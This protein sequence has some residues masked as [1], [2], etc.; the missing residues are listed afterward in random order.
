MLWVIVKRELMDY[1][2]SVRFALT[3][4][5]CLGIMILSVYVSIQDYEYRLEEYKS[6]VKKHDGYA[7]S[8]NAI[9]RKPE[10]LS[11]LAQGLDRK[12]GGMIETLGHGS[13]YVTFIGAT[14]NLATRQSHYLKELASVDFVFVIRVIYALLAI[15]ISYNLIS[16]ENE[17]G[18]LKLCLSNSIPRSVIVLGKFFGGIILLLASLT[19]GFLIGFIMLL[20]SSTVQLGSDEWI[21]IGMIY[22]AS[23]LYLICF[24]SIGTFVSSLT[25]TSAA[26]L[27]VGII[28][29]LCFV[30]VIPNLTTVLAIEI[31]KIPT[32][33]EMEE[34]RNQHLAV[35][36][37][38]LEKLFE[39]GYS[40]QSIEVG[41]EYAY[42]NGRIEDFHNDYTNKLYNQANLVQRISIISPASVF[43]FAVLQLAATD[44]RRYRN[45][46]WRVRQYT[47][48]YDK[49]LPL[50]ITGQYNECQ[51][52][53]KM[54]SESF[55][56]RQPINE[57]LSS[58]IPNIFILFLFNLLFFL[59]TYI[60]FLRYEVK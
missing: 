57:S 54:A 8:M 40:F 41:R 17:T 4:I 44:A 55:D 9:Y 59:S 10:M 47:D 34:G 11:I 18:T 32:K 49:A 3:I 20:L 27:L 25:K 15:F 2:V 42:A 39:A 21:R 51:K 50:A 29:W 13:R 16:G 36:D 38:R 7:V 45:I 1:M 22:L 46:L 56:I 26:S 23:I 12:L 33:Y 60:A 6:S 19:I 48:E 5:L 53:I 35:L 24:F 43:R 58:A 52:I 30:F 37:N 31:Q 14:G 28:F